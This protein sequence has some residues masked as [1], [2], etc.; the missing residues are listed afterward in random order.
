MKLAQCGLVV[1]GDAFGAYQASCGGGDFSTKSLQLAGL[2]QGLASQCKS[3]V[4]SG[5]TSGRPSIKLASRVSSGILG[6]GLVDRPRDGEP[7]RANDEAMRCAVT[8]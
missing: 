4:E 5:T 8:G 2:Q 7:S 3:G 6:R 1:L